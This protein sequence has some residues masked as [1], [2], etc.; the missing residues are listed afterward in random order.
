MALC[1][2]RLWMEWELGLRNFCFCSLASVVKEQ[3]SVGGLLWNKLD[4][5]QGQLICELAAATT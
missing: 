3:A 1:V 4:S 5:W 2:S